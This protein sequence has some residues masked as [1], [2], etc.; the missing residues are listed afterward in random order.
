MKSIEYIPSRDELNAGSCRTTGGR[1]VKRIG[2]LR[3]YY[4]KDFTIRGISI[5][6]PLKEFKEAFRVVPVGGLL[7]GVKFSEEEIKKCRDEL[8]RNIERNW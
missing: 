3:L 8:L 2:P 4:D 6:E 7:S 5:K 1:R